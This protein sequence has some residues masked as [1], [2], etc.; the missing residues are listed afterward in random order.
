MPRH[1]PTT[2]AFE[3]FLA[4][5]TPPV[6]ANCRSLRFRDPVTIEEQRQWAR[7]HAELTASQNLGDI[8]R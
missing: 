3:L 7:V 4:R 8:S 5:Q 1:N 6:A 2:E